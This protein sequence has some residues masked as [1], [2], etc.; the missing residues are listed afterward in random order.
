MLRRHQTSPNCFQ[1]HAVVHSLHSAI[2]EQ[3]Q[4]IA[5]NM[6]Y[7]SPIDDSSANEQKN[8]TSLVEKTD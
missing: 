3:C 2:L 7:A 8:D 1:Q 5:L 6:P 4:M